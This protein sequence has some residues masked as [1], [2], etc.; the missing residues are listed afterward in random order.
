MSDTC[1]LMGELRESTEREPIATLKIKTSLPNNIISNLGRTNRSFSYSKPSFFN[2]HMGIN[3]F[4]WHLARHKISKN[5]MV[6]M[7]SILG[8]QIPWFHKLVPIFHTNQQN[9]N[10]SFTLVCCLLATL[11]LNFCISLSQHTSEDNPYKSYNSQHRNYPRLLYFTSVY[12]SPASQKLILSWM[13][14]PKFLQRSYGVA[15]GELVFHNLITLPLP[16]TQDTPRK[17]KFNM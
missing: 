1:N 10:S 4:L 15:L 5:S 8:S 11:I 17:N 16:H 9:Q 6:F 12:S 2:C 13:C 3:A 7:I 14:F